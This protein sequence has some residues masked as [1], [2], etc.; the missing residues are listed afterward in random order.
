MKKIFMPDEFET[1]GLMIRK[2][3]PNEAEISQFS[4]LLKDNLP[5]SNFAY[6]S[7]LKMDEKELLSAFQKQERQDGFPCQEISYGIFKNDVMCGVQTVY[8]DLSEKTAEIIYLTDRQYQRQ[9][10][11]SSV[12]SKMEDV[13]F[14][15]G[16]DQIFLNCHPLNMS[17]RCM[18]GGSGYRLL[19]GGDQD[20]FAMTY[21]KTKEEK[22]DMN[23]YR[24]GK[25]NL[26]PVSVYKYLFQNNRT[27]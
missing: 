18:A 14:E 23:A 22:Q 12:L 24:R 13:L 15:G 19:N 2:I 17:G 7:S 4:K 3:K 16:V 20:A 8:I 27:R 9:K 25:T 11:A 5:E 26:M 10:I 1:F 21:V 6:S